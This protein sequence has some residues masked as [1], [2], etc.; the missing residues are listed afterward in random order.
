MIS[1]IL[2]KKQAEAR[3]NHQ[4]LFIRYT[5]AILI[6]FTVLNLFNEYWDY[7]IIDSFSISFL[8]AVLL[9]LLLQVTIVIEHRIA[10]YF[11][12]KSGLRPKILR[13]FSSWIVLFISKLII[14][15]AI[16]FTFGSYILFSGPIHGLVAFI[17][18][19]IAILVAEQLIIR[20][21][22]SLA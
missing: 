3:S 11:K 10:S 20:I 17:I 18:V 21:Y 15:E 9:Q 6:D 16:N 14:L 1:N 13:L 22:K 7:V 5:L 12:S 2:P 19:V 8:A 4:Q